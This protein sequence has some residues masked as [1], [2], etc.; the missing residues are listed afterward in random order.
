MHSLFLHFPHSLLLLPSV[1]H[2]AEVIKDHSFSL[3][4]P[5]LL[6]FSSGIWTTS[7]GR[8]KCR[9]EDGISRDTVVI[10]WMFNVK[11]EGELSDSMALGLGLPVLYH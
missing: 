5:T 2:R 3:T 8:V 11:E 4:V 6:D 1:T 10:V 9:L 7:E